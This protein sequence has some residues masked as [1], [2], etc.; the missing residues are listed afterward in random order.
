MPIRNVWRPFTKGSIKASA[1]EE[2]GVY[3]IGDAKGEVVYIGKSETSIKSRL[4]KHKEKSRF[5]LAK[6]FR[7][8]PVKYPKDPEEIE[9]KLCE[10]YKKKHKGN[11]PRYQDRSPKTKTS[12]FPVKFSF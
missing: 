5:R 10:A 7:F 11:L 12:L 2:A 4:L 6:Q 9:N 3:E 1:S 8:M